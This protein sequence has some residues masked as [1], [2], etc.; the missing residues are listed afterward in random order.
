M[1]FRMALL[2]QCAC[3]GQLERQLIRKRS[4]FQGSHELPNLSAQCPGGH[5]HPH[6]RGAGRAASAAQHP[7]EPANPLGLPSRA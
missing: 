4:H 2:G 6:L 5:D 3:G 1:P 7:E